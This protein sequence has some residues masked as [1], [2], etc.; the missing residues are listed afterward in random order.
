MLPP[1]ASVVFNHYIPLGKIAAPVIVKNRRGI[2]P[3]ASALFRHLGKTVTGR[4][5]CHGDVIL[6]SKGGTFFGFDFE[7][8]DCNCP[9]F[10][11]ALPCMEKESGYDKSVYIHHITSGMVH[12]SLQDI[13]AGYTSKKQKDGRKLR[14]RTKWMERQSWQARATGAR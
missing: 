1:A 2:L 8:T 14:G 13:A 9:L 7:S 10:S 11:P 12:L 3:P 4:I 5:L 6:R